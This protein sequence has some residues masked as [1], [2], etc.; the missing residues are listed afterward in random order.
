MDC[1]LPSTSGVKELK[2]HILRSET[3]AELSGALGHLTPGEA[4]QVTD[5]AGSL[6]AC[7]LPAIRDVKS[8]VLVIAPDEDQAETFR[9]DAVLSLGEGRVRHFSPRPRHDAYALEIQGTIDQVETLR[10]LQKGPGTVIVASPHAIVQKLPAPASFASLLIELER[11]GEYPFEELIGRLENYGFEK[12]DFVE[13]CGDIAVRGGILDVFPFNGEHPVR[14]EFWGD[15]LESVRE[16]DVLSQRS[17]RTLG[18][19]TLLP[20]LEPEADATGRASPAGPLTHSL[21][22][23]LP[24]GTLVILVSP[25]MV[26]Q[27]IEELEHDGVDDIF[28]F[29]DLL[30]RARNFPLLVPSLKGETLPEEFTSR[31]SLGIGSISQPSFNGNVG[32]LARTVSELL[33]K[34]FTVWLTSDTEA[35]S[36]RLRDLIEETLTD[37]GLSRGNA[38]SIRDEDALRILENGNTLFL[39]ETP[40]HGFV[41]EREKLAVLTEHEIFGRIR[42][43]GTEKRRRFKGFSQKELQQL[44]PGD[45]V[46]HVD[47]GIGVFDGLTKLKVGG[48]DQEVMKLQFLENDVLYVNL[49]FLNRVQKYS[50]KEGHRPNLSRLGG[51]EWAKAKA[52]AKRRLKDIARDLIALYARRKREAGFAFSPDT[53]WQKELEAS[54]MYEDTPDQ[55]S[56]TQVVKGDME[57]PSPMDRLICGDVGFGKTEVAVRAAFKA[58]SD[59]KQVAVLVPTTILALQHFQTFQDRLSRYT[60]SIDHLTRFRSR[61]EQLSIIERLR[62]GSL[63]IVI[64]THRLLSKDVEFRNLGL[65]IIDEEH[66]FGVTAK[67]K[68]RERRASVDTLSLTATPIPRTLHF[69]LIGARDLSLINT[70]PRNRIPV[71]TEIIPADTKGRQLHWQVVREAILHELRRHGQ[72]YVVHDRVDNIESIAAQVRAHVPEARVRIIHGQMP[73]HDTEKALMAFLERDFD[74]L[75]ATKIIES[76]LD[77]P[78]VNTIV[79]NRADRFGLAELYQ[80]RGR[81]GRSNVQAFAYLLVPPLTSL[82]KPTL[83]RLQAIEE[84]TELGSGFNLAMRDLEIRGAGNLLGAEQSGFIMEMGFEL[85]ERILQE[86]VEELKTEEFAGL[87]QPGKPARREEVQVDTD[88]EAILPDLYIDSDIERLD[89]YRRLYQAPSAVELEE[90]QRELSDRFGEYPEEVGNLF[91]ILELRL[92][93]LS[94]GLRRVSLKGDSFVMTLPEEEY[95]EFYGSPGDSNSP[96]QR[97]LSFIASEGTQRMRFHQEGKDLRIQTVVKRTGCRERIRACCDVLST[98]RTAMGPDFAGSRS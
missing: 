18:S 31:G 64:G 57:H 1:F 40:H 52:R 27:E 54:F 9:D 50:S 70:P 43:R 44:R 38:S 72:I 89:I 65:L 77:I 13:T 33:G 5:A 68:L 35:E 25:S 49:S 28:S 19:A 32:H 34:G 14:L 79:I 58:V 36:H 74:V 84:F 26:S 78:N 8:H 7:M 86:A 20:A 81:V 83:R 80:L 24:E 94:I 85:Y 96:F 53:H 39:T 62:S 55:A 88:C 71:V 21:F 17:I 69:S 95:Q 12:K 59:G 61:P 75:V 2:D 46:V 11:G 60:V 92:I 41:W 3:V 67:E 97:L 6:L 73:A 51:G 90:M 76:G 16:F 63:D 87:L 56:A 45:Y 82:P 37:P 42:R 66:R 29:A 98:L 23:Y 30:S 4:L 15:R 47:H 10:E 22:D 91:A 48:A 93:A